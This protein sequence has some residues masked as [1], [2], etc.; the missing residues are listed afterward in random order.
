[1][2]KKNNRDY[3]LFLEDM[4]LSI[5][6]IEEYLVGFDFPKFKKTYLV[7]DAVCRNFEIIGEAANKTPEVV[8]TKYPEIPW[9]KMYG[10]RNMISHEYFGIDYEIIWEIATKNLPKNKLELKKVIDNEKSL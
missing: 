3:I 9:L 4:H 7:V 5:T 10:L 6:R 1:M 8:K 2:Y